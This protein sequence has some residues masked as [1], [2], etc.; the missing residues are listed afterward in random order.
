MSPLFS[1]SQ[2]AQYEKAQ[3]LFFSPEAVAAR[4]DPVIARFADAAMLDT[5]LKGYKNLEPR[6]NKAKTKELPGYNLA[7]DDPVEMDAAELVAQQIAETKNALI[8]GETKDGFSTLSPQQQEMVLNAIDNELYGG[9]IDKI[10]ELGTKN[11]VYPENYPDPALAGKKIPA[12]FEEGQKRA[13]GRQ[14]L[15]DSA[16]MIDRY[17]GA[18]MYGMPRDALHYVAAAN[19]PA[20][21]TDLGNIRMGP[22]SLN[23]SV[24]EFE[25]AQLEN[26]LNTRLGRLQA[27]QFVLDN[28]ISPTQ[29][30]GID[31]RTN[32]ENRAF[33]QMMNKIDEIRKEVGAEELRAYDAIVQ[34]G[35]GKDKA[36]TINADTVI[37]GEA[38]GGKKRRKL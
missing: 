33:A 22:A 6:Y 27:E 21:L 9:A 5:L 28:G 16:Q 14:L 17:T 23:Q 19:N 25:G 35:K 38:I 10:G 24:K 26:A 30:G 15:L 12:I 1:P 11:R 31:K 4:Q 36:V 13:R 29:R 2:R 32:A 18:G 37:M 34:Q 7:V 20:L 8:N 3:A